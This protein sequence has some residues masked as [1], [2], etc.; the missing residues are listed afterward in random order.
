M[1][2]LLDSSAVTYGGRVGL[3]NYGSRYIGPMQ[4][5]AQ[6]NIG[7]LFGLVRRHDLSATTALPTDELAY[8]S[9]QQTL[10]LAHPGLSLMANFSY[11]TSA[12]GFTLSSS[13]I[14]SDTFVGHIAPEPIAYPL[15]CEEP[16]HRRAVRCEEHP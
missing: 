5:E 2:L 3:N 7:N 16:V 14:E 6:L 4:T 15:A 8:I 12:P 10:P 9:V 1:I 11:S 13:E